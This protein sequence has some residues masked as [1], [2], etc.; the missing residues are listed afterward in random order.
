MERSFASLSLKDLVEARD[1]YHWHLTSMTNVVGTAVGLYYVRK[2]D[3]WPSGVRSARAEHPTA[4]AKEPRTFANS[5]VRSYSW[6]CVV[7]LVERWVDPEEFGTGDGRVPPGD[8]VPKTL[9][10]PDGR[11]VP[12]CVVKVDPSEPARDLLPAWTWPKSMVGGGFPL[13]SRSQGVDHVASV[14]GLVTDGH[15]VFA[16][17]SRHVAGPAGAP[18]ETMLRGRR[19]TVGVSTSKQLTRLP[20]SEVYVDLPVR[21][22]FLTLD[23]G[24]VEVGDLDQWTSQVYGLPA[25]GELA[26]LSERNIGTRLVDAHVVAFGAASGRLDGRIAAL[27]YRYRTIGGYDEV[28]D[29]L[30]AP[31]PGSPGSQPGDSGT[32]WHLLEEDTGRLR[33]IALQWGGQSFIADSGTTNFNFTLAANLTNIIRLLDV[34]LVLD[35]NRGAQPFWG[36]TGHYGVAA[37][38]CEQ[39]TSPGLRTLLRENVD[40]ISF[41]SGG[42]DPDVIDQATKDAKDT[43]GFMPLADVADLIWKNLG[44]K[45]PGGR[46]TGFS[47]HGTSGPEHPTHYADIDVA[48]ADGRTLR[49]RCVDDPAKVDVAVWQA[50]YDALGETDSSKRGLL[51]FRVWQF[52]DELVA[53]LTDGDLSRYVCAAGLMA[54]Y[55]G[56]ACQPLHGSHLADGIDSGP[57]AGKGKGVHSAFESY[58]IDFKAGEILTG[59]PASVAALAQNPRPPVSSGHDAAVAVVQLMDRTAHTIDPLALVDAYAATQTGQTKNP[60]HNHAVLEALWTQFGDAT[61]DVLADGALTL[62]GIWE[63]AWVQAGAEQRFAPGDLVAMD[64]DALQALYERPDFVPSLDLD[65]VGAALR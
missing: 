63:A 22:T 11:T 1:N 29:F 19:V 50:T 20:L 62:A 54:H 42:L 41:P 28:T 51:P 14:G 38:A 5:E 43:G 6:P 15:T 30:I 18:V 53:A 56:D 48:D 17:T 58:M 44:T 3:P 2:S 9:Y 57:D 8:M 27:F 25:L 60:T 32:L 46:D 23:A 34:E 7:V 10:M 55:V 21:R 49:Q 36:K 61:I 33:P 16:L 24:L 35:H 26:D 64:R 13:I 39:V 45:V 59:L 4:V 31:L 37:L 65:H 12:V 40:R 47:G 52:Y